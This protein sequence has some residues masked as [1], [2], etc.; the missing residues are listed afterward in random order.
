M[1]VIPWLIHRRW[2]KLH[3]DMVITPLLCYTLGYLASGINSGN[4]VA[5]LLAVWSQWYMRKYRA[6]WYRKYKCVERRPSDFALRA[7]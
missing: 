2:P 4:F 1:P 5:F 3:M 7:T 6:T